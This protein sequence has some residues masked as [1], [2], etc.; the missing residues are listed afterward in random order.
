MADEQHGHELPP[1]V[2]K[3]IKK[4]NK[5]H[6]GSWKIAYADFVTAMM[7][8]FLLMWLLS[9]L[10]KYQLQGVAEYFRRPMK[11]A[12]KNQIEE[13]TITQG[14]KL[15]PLNSIEQKKD[16]VTHQ[17][18]KEEQMKQLI[19]MK[20]HLENEIQKNPQLS[21]YKNQ[22]NFVVSSNGLKITIQDLKDKPMFTVGKADFSRHSDKLLTWLSNEMN[23]YPNRI[24]IIGHTDGLPFP[25][26]SQYGN[27]ELSSDR[28]TATRR[29]LLKYGLQDDKIVRIIGASD[30]DVLG[31]RNKLD[32]A[33]R[34]IEIVVLSDDA[35]KRMQDEEQD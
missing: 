32:S 4:I 15:H 11:E 25:K 5:H 9:L 1:V 35:Y 27:W 30:N 17:M 21:E 28:A 18:S 2:I 14:K 3:R 12:F 24:V 22:L 16:K 20:N 13:K 6:G 10:N 7:A 29:V 23:Q 31:S 34:R 26:N 19:A 33:N 8:F